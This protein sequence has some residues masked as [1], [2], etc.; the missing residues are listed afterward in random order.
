[1]YFSSLQLISEAAAFML[2]CVFFFW[3]TLHERFFFRTV[4]IIVLKF[5]S[6]HDVPWC[7][8][9]NCDVLQCLMMS[10]D[11]KWCS[12]DVPWFPVMSHDIPWC[13]LMS[14]DVLWC[15]VLSS[16]GSMMS[17]DFQLCY[18]DVPWCPMMFC[19]VLWFP[20][21]SWVVLL[22]KFCLHHSCISSVAE[23]SVA[24][25]FFSM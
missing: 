19:D 12:N 16:D 5:F 20:I 13:P 14:H 17:H 18:S 23:W 3:R 15:P 1:M 10:C 8:A 25:E 21:M 6:R 9:M 11:V 24:V 22:V 7:L 2:F 4:C